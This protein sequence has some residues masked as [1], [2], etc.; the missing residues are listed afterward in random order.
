M[1]GDRNSLVRL[2]DR[3]REKTRVDNI[4]F[5]LVGAGRA[6]LIH[7]RNIARRI[8]NAELVA[9]CD[10]NPDSA[11][12]DRWPESSAWTTT[13]G[14]SRHTTPG[15]D[16]RFVVPRAELESAAA[17]GL[18]DD[19]TVGVNAAQTVPFSGLSERLAA[20]SIDLAL[21]PVN[22]RDTYRRSRGVPGNMTFEEAVGLCR[23]SGIPHLVPH[24]FGM[25]DFNTVDEAEL[26]RQAAALE[27][28]VQCLLPS[29]NRCFVLV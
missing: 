2:A 16:C 10:G 7:A 13:G 6:G 21:L 14:M 25:F 18:P 4:R 22:G 27:G 26:R 28:D 9:V 8:P 3:F 19:R 24:H 20:A 1:M 17:I 15:P 11:S 23:R 12:T 29:M 5:C